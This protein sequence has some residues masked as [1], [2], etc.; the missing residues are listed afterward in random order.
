MQLYIFN[1]SLVTANKMADGQVARVKEQTVIWSIYFSNQRSFQRGRGCSD[2]M[3]VG[4]ITTYAITTNVVIS[5]P[6]QAKC[7][8]PYVVKFVSHLRKVRCFLL[9]LRC[10]LPIQLPVTIQLK[11]ALSHD[12]NLNPFITMENIHIETNYKVPYY[13]YP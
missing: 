11:V 10:C 8:Q 1:I 9:V 3:N 12:I 7:D 6:A 2:R 13:C 4:F 5:N